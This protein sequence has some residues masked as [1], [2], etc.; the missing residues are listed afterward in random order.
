MKK[1]NPYAKD[2]YFEDFPEIEELKE[3]LISLLGISLVENPIELLYESMISQPK[4]KVIGLDED[5][6]EYITLFNSFVM[7]DNPYWSE[8]KL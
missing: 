5:E 4:F 7:E 2:E 6:S 1:A 3:K 8:K